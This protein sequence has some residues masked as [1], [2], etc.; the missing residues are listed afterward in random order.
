MKKG[1][2]SVLILTIGSLICKLILTKIN[3][4]MRIS[5]WK[6]I[7]ECYLTDWLSAPREYRWQRKLSIV[8]LVSRLG[9][10]KVWLKS[11]L[12]CS[13]QLHWP[14]L[15]PGWSIGLSKIKWTLS[16]YFYYYVLLTLLAEFPFVRTYLTNW[17]NNVY[18]RW[19]LF[20]RSETREA[21]ATASL[22]VF[23]RHIECPKKLELLCFSL[24]LQKNCKFM[25]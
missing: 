8:W 15:F 12:K 5:V 25:L 6:T 11:I 19:I 22:T 3:C 9:A 4:H 17:W 23:S 10:Y 21:V 1:F 18:T 13:Y 24:L 14:A 16:F 2:S 7:L 20:Q